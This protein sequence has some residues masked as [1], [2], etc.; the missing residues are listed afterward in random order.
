[1]ISENRENLYAYADAGQFIGKS[2]AE[3]FN[4]IYRRNIWTDTESVSGIGSSHN[5]T[6]EIIDKLPRV[7]Q[8]FQITSM[9]DAPCGDFNW[10]SK[11]D[12]QNIA[13]IGADIVENIVVSNNQKFANNRRQFILLDLIDEKTDKF[14]LV[15]SRDCFVHFSFADIF[16]SLENIKNGESKYL[17][18]T[19][20]TEQRLNKDIHTGG[21]RPLNF[22]IS[23]FNFPKP[24]YTLNEKCTEM[25]GR[26]GDKS[27]GLWKVADCL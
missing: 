22:E 17:M 19:T 10:M 6:Q 1:M 3:I 18:T 25:N 21:W 26:F 2:T 5:Q 13:Y 8:D 7:L 14:D 9:L 27:L 11:V 24:L 23:P 20:F 16:K 12:L 15:F 4:E